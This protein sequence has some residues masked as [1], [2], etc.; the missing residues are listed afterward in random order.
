MSMNPYPTNPG[1]GLRVHY[2][3][4]AIRKLATDPY[5]D[6]YNRAFDNCFEMNDG[7]AVVWAL[8]DKAIREPDQ[9]GNS[10]LSEGIRRMFRS[11][12]NGEAYPA[13]WLNT[14]HQTTGKSCQWELFR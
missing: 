2:A 7:D 3:E 12:L 6:I 5:A 1:F 8:M 13:D 11:T 14:Y 9:Y 10:H 4:Q